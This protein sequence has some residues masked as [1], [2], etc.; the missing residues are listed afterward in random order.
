MDGQPLRPGCQVLFM[1]DKGH[2]A[3][4]VIGEGGKYKLVYPH[5]DVP[6]VEYR[7]QLTPPI[8][9]AVPSEDPLKMA[10]NMTL[11]KKGGDSKSDLPFPPRYTS[12]STSKM[13]FT[14][15]QGENKADFALTSK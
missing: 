4:G 1:S 13:S 3:A 9:A 12:T 14:V 11:S 5:G 8:S 7:V 6:A 10:G 15:K 2:T